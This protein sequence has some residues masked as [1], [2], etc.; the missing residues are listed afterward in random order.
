MFLC[1]KKQNTEYEC[2]PW[3][4]WS[5][6]F[7]N[8]PIHKGEKQILDL[9]FTWEKRPFCCLLANKWEDVALNSTEG[10][11]AGIVGLL[12]CF[13]FFMSSFRKLNYSVVTLTWLFLMKMTVLSTWCLALKSHPKQRPSGHK[14]T[15][16][17]CRTSI[18]HVPL[19]CLCLAPASTVKD[20]LPFLFW[21]KTLSGFHL[22]IFLDDMIEPYLP[23]W[24]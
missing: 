1:R 7:E 16:R 4:L 6:L 15:L 8:Q 12:F 17:A 18:P 10:A 11:R 23:V 14:F 5:H 21:W 20:D 22:Y 19:L 13:S 24:L 9:I 3:I 2:R